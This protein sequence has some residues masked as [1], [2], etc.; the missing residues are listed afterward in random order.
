[1]HAAQKQVS[2]EDMWATLESHPGCHR[3][4]VVQTPK[5]E[6]AIAL[7]PLD[8]DKPVKTGENSGYLLSLCGLFSISKDS[9][10]GVA[11]YTAWRRRQ[12]EIPERM[13]GIRD[14]LD[15]AKHICEL[16]RK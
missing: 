14:H 1:M 5:A 9:V 16:D 7:P 8:W 2:M 10:K 6:S 13:L 12:G 11:M 15:E 4:T 3:P